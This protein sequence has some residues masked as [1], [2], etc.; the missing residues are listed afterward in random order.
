MKH[1]FAILPIFMFFLN[2][3]T[4]DADTEDSQLNSKISITLRED[5]SKEGRKFK[6]HCV[7]D[8]T[9]PCSNYSI[10]Y[11]MQRNGSDIDI[12]F[13]NIYKP[14]HCATS[15]GPAK[16]E[17][18]FNI[19]PYDEYTLRII[20]NETVLETQLSITEEKFVVSDSVSEWVTIVNPEIRRLPYNAIW[21][22]VGFS[23]DSFVVKQVQP[24][25][26]TLK[27]LE[28]QEIDLQSGDY[29]YFQVDSSGTISPPVNPG[30]LNAIPFVYLYDNDLTVLR[31]LI[32]HYGKHSPLSITMYTGKGDIY[33]TWQLAQED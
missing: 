2:S 15:F 19:L 33:Y 22:Y 1:L 12:I 26:D 4:N 10:V 30:T 9:F 14:Q 17:I 27:T 8:S 18:D 13:T 29:V 6:L 11:Q 25:F 20:V 23:S 5:I 28:V 32:K 24:F 7:T 16:C 21:G 31:S 3:C